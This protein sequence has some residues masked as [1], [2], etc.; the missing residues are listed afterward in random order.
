MNIFQT[1]VAFASTSNTLFDYR[2]TKKSNFSGLIA[3]RQKI[4]IFNQRKEYITQDIFVLFGDKNQG[5]NQK[6]KNK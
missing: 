1:C 3:R 2:M 5:P 4:S 6:E